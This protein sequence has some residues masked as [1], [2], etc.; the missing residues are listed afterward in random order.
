[1]SEPTLDE[2]GIKHGTDKSSRGHNYLKTY[3]SFLSRYRNEQFTLIEIGGLNGASLAVW[4]EY[5]PKAKIVCLDINPKVTRFQRERVDV[6]IGD[7]GD[8]KFLADV[9]SRYE[10]VKVVIDDGSHRWDHNRIAF[11][12]LFPSVSP[13]GLY[14]VEDLHTNFETRYA[15]N[16]DTPFM[17]VLLEM[18]RTLLA[19][20]EVRR[21]LQSGLS[22]KVRAAL[23]QS[24]YI[25]F[26]S[27]SCIISKKEK[28]EPEAEST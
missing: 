27:R 19:R 25:A 24:E 11:I 14:V 3:E 1:M 5:F 20:G 4:E 17:T 13:G 2:L 6:L 22:P 26:L 12:N 7:S 28:P 23:S 15:G 16:D 21:A 18:S 10:N 9:L 8:P